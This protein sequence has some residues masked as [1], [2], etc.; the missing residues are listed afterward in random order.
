MEHRITPIGSTLH[1]IHGNESRQMIFPNLEKS[2]PIFDAMKIA[3][4]L[5]TC[6]KTDAI[7]YY[8]RK[9]Y[10]CGYSYLDTVPQ[11]ESH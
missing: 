8:G 1:G 5:Y 3:S 2:H 7:S 11:L 6:K 9:L 4:V 10:R